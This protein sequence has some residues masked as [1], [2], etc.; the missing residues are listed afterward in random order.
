MSG[1]VTF[2]LVRPR[3]P[4]NLGAVARVMKNFGFSRLALVDPQTEISNESREW[5][6]GADDVLH[7]A[8][9][10]SD[11]ASAIARAKFVIG[12]S[13]R[14]RTLAPPRLDLPKL[15]TAIQEREGPVALVFGPERTGLTSEELALCHAFINIPTNSRFPSLNLAQ[16]VVLI[17]WELRRSNALGEARKSAQKEKPRRATAG[18]CE[19]MLKQAEQA[20]LA[21][22]F[23]KPDKTLGP[24]LTLRAILDRAELSTDDVRFLRGI[25][26]QINNLA[27][28]K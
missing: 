7:R 10:F 22:D 26:R 12:A 20:L 1:A 6:C 14:R 19:A 24:M 25:F 28:R 15:T 11:L 17:A 3:N 9:L 13:G 27:R 21:I 8:K 2:V 4:G 23:L 16:A 18:Q 5:A